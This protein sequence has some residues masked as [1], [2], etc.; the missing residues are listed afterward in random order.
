[1]IKEM[2]L[3]DNVEIA[4]KKL[5]YTI[6]YIEFVLKENSKL[7]DLVLQKEKEITKLQ[8]NIEELGCIHE[9]VENENNRLEEQVDASDQKW[10]EIVPIVKKLYTLLE[11]DA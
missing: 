7:N 4:K 2:S 5:E 6:E 8:T 11:L 10:E 3:K 1:M 9:G